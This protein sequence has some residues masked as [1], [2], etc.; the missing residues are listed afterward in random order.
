MNRDDPPQIRH[1]VRQSRQAPWLN[2]W[3]RGRIQMSEVETGEVYPVLHAAERAALLEYVTAREAG[4]P[5]TLVLKA[6]ARRLERHRRKYL[7]LI[8]QMGWDLP[9]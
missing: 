8:E 9:L 4:D 3:T 5:V 7:A 1:P 2:G 6:R